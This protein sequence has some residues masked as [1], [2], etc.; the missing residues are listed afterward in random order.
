MLPEAPNALP[1]PL[2]PLVA[3]K[4]LPVAPKMLPLEVPLPAV[5]PKMLPVEAFELAPL[6]AK[7]LPLEEAGEAVKILPPLELDT[8]AG[9]LPNLGKQKLG[10]LTECEPGS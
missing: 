1:P 10:W 8:D 7:M 3:P 6:E 2:V 5:A 4:L 9:A